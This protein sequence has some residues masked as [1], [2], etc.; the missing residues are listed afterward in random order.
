MLAEVG[1][2]DAIGEPAN[3]LVKDCAKSK[4]R[5]VFRNREDQTKLS[6]LSRD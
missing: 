5:I 2:I 3:Y 4:L 6:L 1:G